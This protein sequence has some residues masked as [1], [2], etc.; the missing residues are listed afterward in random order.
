[1]ILTSA[2][3]QIASDK[4]R[5]RVVN[6]GRRFG[7]TTLAVLEMIAKAV[8]GNNRQICYIAPTYQQA[9]D[10]AWQELKKLCQPAINKV[11]ES[12]LEIIVNTT[13]GGTSSILLRG[14]ESI[15]TLRGQKFDFIVIDEI[16]SMRNWATNWQEVIRPT[17]TD[18]RGEVLFISTPKGFNHFYDLY[19]LESKDTDYKSFHFTTY[20]NEHIPADEIEK[21][22]K[23]LTEDRFAQEYN[24]DFR[25]TEGL[26]YKEFDRNRHL[27]DFEPGNI[28]EYI[29]GIDFGF[30]N[31]A[32]VIHIKRDY[33]NNYW[34]TDEWYQTGRTEEQIADYV[35]SCGFNAVYPDPENPSA[36]AVLNT[37]GVNVC[38]VVKGKDS[39]QSGI[40]RVRD[41]FKRNKLKIHKNCGNII[42][43]LETYAYP[44]KK[45][46]K[47]EYEN[48]IKENDHALDALRMAITT[49]QPED[50]E[51]STRMALIHQVRRNNQTNH[52][53]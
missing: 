1:M 6:C 9:R 18:V 49:N 52:A 11:N 22:K 32:A 5:F 16:A 44:E 37:K 41:L 36:I 23:E 10:I 26:V 14:W 27:F 46:G 2:Q 34:V 8:Y 47:N 48:P 7:K 45:D 50:K 31:P 43:E 19:N 38:E 21:A 4:H 28:S 12:R 39:V 42:S 15:E 51:W 40:N 3:S 20:D 30:T 53:R 29:G 13:K 24:A 35:R 25:K 17:L 33:D